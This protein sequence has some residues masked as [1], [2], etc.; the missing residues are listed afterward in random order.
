MPRN[1][2]DVPQEYREHQRELARQIGSRIR[3][4]RLQLGF[5]Q[6]KLREQMEVNSVSMTKSQL[7]RV[8][9]GELLP[10]AVEVIA[11]S[12]ALGVTYRW[13]LEGEE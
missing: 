5:S 3:E 9:L 11:L 12:E 7:S 6:R 4:R 8:E 10:D 1:R 13:L 2:T